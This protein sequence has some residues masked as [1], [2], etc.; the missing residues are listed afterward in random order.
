MASVPFNHYFKIVKDNDCVQFHP[1]M[2]DPVSVDD[3]DDSTLR[4]LMISCK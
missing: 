4:E 1:E 2:K 3:L